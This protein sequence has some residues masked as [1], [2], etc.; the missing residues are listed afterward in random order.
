M[1][2]ILIF[3]F[4]SDF[5]I[6]NFTTGDIIY[7]DPI[8]ENDPC[9]L[10]ENRTFG[11]C[12]KATECINHFELFKKKK[13]NLKICKYETPTVICCPNDLTERVME[14]TTENN[15]QYKYDVYKDCLLKNYKHSEKFPNYKH[16]LEALI[17]KK[18]PLN[19]ENCHSLLLNCSEFN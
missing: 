2:K 12:K 13:I 16:F 18:I 19:E 3:I 17:S 14:K 9:D 1:L 11:T 10:Y 15:S 5:L 6:R 8:D 7:S 4:F